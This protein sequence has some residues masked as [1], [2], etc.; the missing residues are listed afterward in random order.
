M[1]PLGGHCLIAYPGL[2][3][4]TIDNENGT[5]KTECKSKPILGN[6]SRYFIK[7][8]NSLWAPL[9]VSKTW[10]THRLLV[11]FCPRMKERTARA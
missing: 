3:I 9:Y 7:L 8:A 2:I 1:F 11:T 4:K 6:Q 5:A 10:T